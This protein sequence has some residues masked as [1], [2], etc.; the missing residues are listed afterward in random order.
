MKI[1]EQTQRTMKEKILKEIID[2]YCQIN[3]K[4]DICICVRDI[5]S[6]ENV[7]KFLN[8]YDYRTLRLL[9][10]IQKKKDINKKFISSTIVL[11]CKR[12]GYDIKKSTIYYK[13]KCGEKKDIQGKTS[14]IYKYST[15]GCYIISY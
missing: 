8:E 4:G 5:N 7:E 15:S 2:K 11:M 12:L 1:I 3:E 6:D 9:F 10:N 13:F 14:D